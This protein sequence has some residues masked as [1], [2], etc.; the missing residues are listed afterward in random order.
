M[1]AVNPKD[2]AVDA[3]QFIEQVEAIA[4]PNAGRVRLYLTALGA[5]FRRSSGAAVRLATE[6]DLALKADDSDLA[7]LQSLKIGSTA[8]SSF[9]PDAKLLGHAFDVT[10]NADQTVTAGVLT[11]LTFPTE[12]VDTEGWYDNVTTNRFTPLLAGTYFL[13]GFAR[14]AGAA[15]GSSSLS[16]YK[17]GANVSQAAAISPAATHQS[18][19][20]AGLFTANG[21]SDF[22]NLQAISQTTTVFKATLQ[23]RFFG[24]KVF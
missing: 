12:N 14:F 17:N 16:I 15:S 8:L 9:A 24:F 22:F 1:P 21:S 20:V 10:A 2:A 4:A 11:L 7:A 13:A 23:A 18:L 5:Y 3:Y 6:T 19:F